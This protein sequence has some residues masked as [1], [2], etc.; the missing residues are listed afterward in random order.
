MITAL[1]YLGVRTDRLPDW[2]D[3]AGGQLGMQEVE[4]GA[5]QVA[6][7]MD[8]RRQRLIV[9]AEPG[10]ALACMGWEVADAASL[11]RLCARLS[12]AGVEVSPGARDLADRR[13]VTDLALARDPAGNR[14][15]FF[16]GPMLTEDP[17]VP[18]GPSP[19]SRPAPSA[20]ATRS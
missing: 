6:F 2:S 4:R 19:A 3:Y 17:F 15:E 9:T 11:D 20:W 13:F 16:H 14:L 1:G 5:G 12:D 10:A 18:G 8:D 7:R